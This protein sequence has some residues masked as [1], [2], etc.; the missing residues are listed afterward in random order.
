MTTRRF[1]TFAAATAVIGLTAGTTVIAIQE[2]KSGIVWPEPKVIAAP[3]TVGAPPSDATILFSGK[4]LSAWQGGDKWEIKDGYAITR[5]GDI[6]TKESFGD[7]QLHVEF[8]TPSKIVGRGQG[9][10]NS[11]IFL[12]DRYEVQVLDSFDNTTYFDGQCGAIYKQ[13]PPMVNVCRKPGEWQSYD[14]LYTAPRFEGETL[15]TPAYITVLQN[16]VVIHNHFEIKGNTFFD[17]PASYTAHPLKQPI[18]LQ[19]HG[20]DTMFRNIW[21]R[22]MTPVVGTLPKK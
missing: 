9:R 1:F 13:S 14:I 19:F 20:N 5:K 21:I 18:H 16:G 6:R 15:K 3:A 4:D 8:C 10:G 2:Y 11:G 22:E 7:C 12:S 17:R